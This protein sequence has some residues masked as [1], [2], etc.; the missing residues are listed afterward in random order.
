MARA[1]GR[2]RLSRESDESTSVERQ[3]ELIQRWA[4]DNG[5]TVVAWA[6]DIDVSG[7][8]S[9]FDA[10]ALA[11][12]L[13]ER[14]GDWDILVAWKL[15]RLARRSIPLHKLFGWIQDHNK[16]L[17]CISDN[18]D[19]SNWVGRL[20]A[21]VVAGVAEGE[22]EAIRERTSASYKKLMESG[23]WPGGVTPYGWKPVKLDTG[24]YKLELDPEAAQVLRRITNSY[25]DGNTLA[26]IANNLTTDGIATPRNHIN[27]KS[28]GRW[29]PNSVRNMLYSK[30]LIG[31]T[32]FKGQVL[33]DDQGKPVSG[34]PPIISVDQYQRIQERLA[35][36]NHLK[37]VPDRTSPLLGVLKCWDCGE[38]I[39]L[40]R[41]PNNSSAYKCRRCPKM[42]TIKANVI[43]ALVIDAFLDELG[44][45][46]VTQR[47]VTPANDLSLEISE[48]EAAYNDLV[49]Y[50]PNARTAE[51][52]TKLYAQLDLIEQR[53]QQLRSESTTA[54]TVEWIESGQT[55]RDLWETLDEQ[56]RRLLMVKSGFTAKARP[57]TKGTRWHDPIFETEFVVPEDLKERLGIQS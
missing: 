4:K 27:G 53:L 31:W 34:L 20:V 24:G 44:D 2:I 21:S 48:T 57:L 52:R 5:H 56:E 16:T 38:N 33:L 41:N 54:D 42:S 30:N 1:L 49:A 7:A 47:K 13:S 40:S 17:V 36:F 19:L 10:P 43:Y 25:L 6:E 8:I 15:D 18:I 22:L 35:E 26:D 12:Y 23:R 37:A 55:Y 14:A 50:I 46:P 32:T 11:P 9:P 29:N 28:G 39:Y 3:R 51:A 45:Y